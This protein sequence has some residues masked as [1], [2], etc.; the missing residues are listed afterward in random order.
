VEMS[1]EFLKKKKGLCWR[2]WW[3]LRRMEGKRWTLSPFSETSD[4]LN[5]IGGKDN[6][7][8]QRYI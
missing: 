5:K 7:S 8:W 3:S 1:F 6:F 2:C 4:F